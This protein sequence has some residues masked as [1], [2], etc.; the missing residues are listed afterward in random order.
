MEEE[1]ERRQRQI[2]KLE[3][4]VKTLTEELVKG[5]EII[6]KLQG[7]IRNYHTKVGNSLFPVFDMEKVI[8]F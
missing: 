6:K 7:E 1:L 5:N 8:L 3:M 4:S 2:T